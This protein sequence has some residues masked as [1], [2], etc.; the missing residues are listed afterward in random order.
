MVGRTHLLGIITFLKAR[1][2]Y[3]SAPITQTPRFSRLVYPAFPTIA[4]VVLGMAGY[5]CQVTTLD[6]G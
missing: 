1:N 2:G 6:Y 3:F 5:T 4:M